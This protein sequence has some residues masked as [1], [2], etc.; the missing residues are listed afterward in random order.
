M[1]RLDD[2]SIIISAYRMPSEDGL[3][4][5]ARHRNDEGREAEDERR[6]TRRVEHRAVMRI[7]NYQ[8]LLLLS[9]SLSNY[10]HYYRF[11]I[12]Y[13]IEATKRSHYYNGLGIV[14]RSSI[15][16]KFKFISTIF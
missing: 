8:S 5:H 13:K 15:L 3:D 12:A 14:R 11:N 16:A 1:C 6:A 2:Q 9:L 7:I 4:L 10:H